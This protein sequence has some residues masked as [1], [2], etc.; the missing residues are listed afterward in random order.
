M[1]KNASH[2]QWV[3]KDASIATISC[4]PSCNKKNIKNIRGRNKAPYG[5]YRGAWSD[6]M[7]GR[8]YTLK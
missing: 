8:P 6:D 1:I 4:V 2:D 7:Y 5:G 3:D